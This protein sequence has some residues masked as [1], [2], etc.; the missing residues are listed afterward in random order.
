M[1][2]GANRTVALCRSPH[3]YI[4]IT[5]PQATGNIVIKITFCSIPA[6]LGGLELI[7]FASFSPVSKL[8][9]T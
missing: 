1:N 5:E 7:S 8:S 2:R 4:D 9:L 3:L 6:D